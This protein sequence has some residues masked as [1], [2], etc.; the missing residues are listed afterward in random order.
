[1]T[2]SEGGLS[3]LELRFDNLASDPD[4]GA[5]LSGVERYLGTMGAM[6][7]AQLEPMDAAQRRQAI[8]GM[9]GRT[10]RGISVAEVSFEGETDPEAPALELDGVTKIRDLELLHGIE[11]PPNAGFE[12]LAGFLLMRLGHIPKPGESGPAKPQ[13]TPSATPQ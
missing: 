13:A 2:E 5:D 3:S 12:T 11:I 7:K 8:E 4:G 10:F 6:L 1:M 9:L